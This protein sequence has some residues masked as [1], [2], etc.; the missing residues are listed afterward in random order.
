MGADIP[1]ADLLEGLGE[2]GARA[3]DIEITAVATL[4]DYAHTATRPDP[5]R[6]GAR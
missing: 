2:A 5:E 3:F 1:T 6:I 4:L